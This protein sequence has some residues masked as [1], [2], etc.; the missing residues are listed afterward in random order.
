MVLAMQILT[1]IV[2]PAIPLLI[3]VVMIR[4][5]SNWKWPGI[6]LVGLGILLYAGLLVSFPVSYSST[7]G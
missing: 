6:A 3:G 5:H 7:S 2:V 1:A 4:H